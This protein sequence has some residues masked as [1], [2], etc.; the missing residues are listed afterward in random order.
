MNHKEPRQTEGRSH[1]PRLEGV[2]AER[3]LDL[4]GNQTH[5][6]PLP[7]GP[8]LLPNT[9]RSQRAE[10]PDAELSAAN[11]RGL[12]LDMLHTPHKRHCE[13]SSAFPVLQP[14]TRNEV[15]SFA[16]VMISET[17]GYCSKKCRH[18]YGHSGPGW[19]TVPG[20]QEPRSPRTDWVIRGGGATYF[21]GPQS[22]HL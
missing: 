1:T 16:Q 6:P 8:D 15:R 9:P 3:V 13:M 14:R 12:T 2:G 11:S 22:L 19:A 17:R 5:S 7:P 10:S 20:G 21:S 4:G 18:M